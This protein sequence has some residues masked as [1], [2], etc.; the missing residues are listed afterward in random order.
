MKKFILYFLAGY[1]ILAS[2]VSFLPNSRLIRAASSLPPRINKAANFPVWL[3][4]ELYALI[5]GMNTAG[6]IRRFEMIYF[7][8]HN[9]YASEAL[10][11]WGAAFRNLNIDPNSWVPRHWDYRVDAH[12]DSFRISARR[13]A[14]IFEGRVMWFELSAQWGGDYPLWPMKDLSFM[15]HYFKGDLE[16]ITGDQESA[17]VVS[18]VREGD[19]SG[20]QE[21]LFSL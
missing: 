11:E 3:L 5:N 7:H 8:E 13:R 12:G 16:K 19:V 4:Q 17:R 10:E 15:R 9:A 18:R 20:I 2:F 1:F 21:N 6:T 14:G